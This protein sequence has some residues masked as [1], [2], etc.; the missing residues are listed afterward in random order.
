MLVFLKHNL[1]IFLAELRQI[2]VPFCQRAGHI[3]RST[4]MIADVDE[5][6]CAVRRTFRQ[7]RSKDGASLYIKTFH[8]PANRCDVYIG[9]H[10]PFSA[11]QIKKLWAKFAE[12]GGVFVVMSD[13]TL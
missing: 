3:L 8:Q 1:N 7:L 10:S 6:S 12:I 13:C 11:D 2:K 9:E 4:E 5:S